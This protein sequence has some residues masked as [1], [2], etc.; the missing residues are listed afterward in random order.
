MLAPGASTRSGY[1]RTPRTR[2]AACRDA[3]RGCA[4]HRW[5]KGSPFESCGC[6]S[7]GSTRAAGHPRSS[8]FPASPHDMPGIATELPSFPPPKSGRGADPRVH[9]SL[10]SEAHTRVPPLKTGSR[11][12]DLGS[13]V[14]FPRSENREPGSEN[15]DSK[16][17]GEAHRRQLAR[18]RFA[19]SRLSQ[20]DSSTNLRLH[21]AGRWPGRQIHEHP[22]VEPQ[23]RHL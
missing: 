4:H 19:L 16:Q 20:C 3:S 2:S 14:S 13:R 8:P 17:K 12:S 5:D 6:R 21:S 15:R 18:L 10:P 23:F 7:D 9:P 22:L 11:I 1:C